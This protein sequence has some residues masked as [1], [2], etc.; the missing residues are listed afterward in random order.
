[1]QR[2]GG[3]FPCFIPGN[4][5]H[6]GVIRLAL[7]VGPFEKLIASALS[8]AE[9]ACVRYNWLNSMRVKRRRRRVIKHLGKLIA[10]LRQLRRQLS[11]GLPASAH[12]RKLNIPL[13]CALKTKLNYTDE[14]LNSDLLRGVP[15]VDE[16]PRASAFPANDTISPMS[17]LGVKGSLDATNGKVPKSLS[18]STY[19]II[20]QNDG[21]FRG[22]SLGRVAFRTNTRV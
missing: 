4:S 13:I 20:K 6:E 19:A 21:I 14:T 18:K 22:R 3:S 16:N 11:R 17:L 8:P 2:K 12:A 15:T 7:E 10:R 9:H 5:S 1:M